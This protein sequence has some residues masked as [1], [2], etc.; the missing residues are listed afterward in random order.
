MLFPMLVLGVFTLV[1]KAIR[2]PFNQFNQQGMDSE[3]K[4]N[5]LFDKC[6]KRRFKS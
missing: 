4:C 2:I 3:R 1:A 6:P 5:T